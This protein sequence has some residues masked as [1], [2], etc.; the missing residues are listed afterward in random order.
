[1]VKKTLICDACGKEEGWDNAYPGGRP[2]AYMVNL[3]LIQWE[4]MCHD[5]A[6]KA[7]RVLTDAFE[8][9]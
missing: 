5:C 3:F 1:M 2:V 6:E 8:K 9:G 7:E 4:Y